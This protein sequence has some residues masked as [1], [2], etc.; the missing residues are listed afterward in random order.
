MIA[1]LV[2]RMST[3]VDVNP[4]VLDDDT[5]DEDE[6]DEND[7]IVISDEEQ[8]IRYDYMVGP[9]KGTRK[10]DE[11]EANKMDYEKKFQ[12]VLNAEFLPVEGTMLGA[13]A[14]PRSKLPLAIFIVYFLFVCFLFFLSLFVS[15]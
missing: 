10:E 15:S 5:P 11:E 3:E 9:W 7:E 14:K 4:D 6:E 1:D 8:Q 13:T 12:R 2:R